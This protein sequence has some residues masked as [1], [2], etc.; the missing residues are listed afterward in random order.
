MEVQELSNKYFICQSLN[1]SAIKNFTIYGERHSGTKWIEE[2]ISRRFDLPVTYEYGWKHFF[3]FCDFAKLNKAKNTLF[4]CVV[5]NIYHWFL[6]MQKEPHHLPMSSNIADII[7]WK[8]IVNDKEILEDRNWIDGI[9]YKNIFEMREYKIL[10]Q[11]FCLHFLVDNYVFIRYE[12]F[13]N[14]NNSILDTISEKFNMP[15]APYEP[16]I[17]KNKL[18][19]N[20]KLIAKHIPT[21]NDSVCWGIEN[22]IGYHKNIF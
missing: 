12:D 22:H 19:I 21:I 17:N 7:P 10:F 14:H 5:R 15:A 3:G 4:I 16:Y 1:N 6:A 18:Q 20:K 13:I 2:V 11:Y 9:Q 8:S